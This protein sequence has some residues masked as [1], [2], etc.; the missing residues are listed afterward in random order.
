MK[1]TPLGVTFPSGVRSRLRAMNPELATLTELQEILGV[2]RRTA[3]RYCE[4]EDFPEPI[5]RIAGG[6]IRVWRRVDVETWAKT[7]LPL[8]TGRPRK[9]SEG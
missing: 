7:H 6:R 3:Q 4:R 5:E 2:S 8:P 9:P 1:A